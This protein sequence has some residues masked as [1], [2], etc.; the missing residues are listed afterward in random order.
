VTHLVLE[1]TFDP[2]LQ[3]AVFHERVRSSGWC[4]DQHRLQWHG[5][6]LS[7][8]ARTLICTFSAPDA[9]SARTALRQAGADIARLWTSSVHVADPPVNANVLVERSLPEP[10]TFEQ[11]QAR[12]DE[13]RW[14]LDQHRVRWS[15]SYL[16]TDGRRMLCLYEAPDAES[17]RVA[18]REAGLPVERLWAFGRL[19]PDTLR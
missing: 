10:A 3:V 6:F 5:S 1:R 2:P 11:L 17:V 13:R 12:E 4:F 9:E 14:C 7:L 19:G 8:D 18:Q 16:S 15:R